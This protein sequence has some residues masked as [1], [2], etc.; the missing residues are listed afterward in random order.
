LKIFTAK[1]REAGIE[2]L[3]IKETAEA[4]NISKTSIY[5]PLKTK[6]IQTFKQNGKTYIDESGLNIIKAY[7]ATE[8]HDT[9]TDILSNTPEGDFQDEFQLSNDV[10][11]ARIITLLENERE[12]KNKIIQAL[13]Q[14]NQLLSNALAND[15]TATAT[16]AKPWY[17][18]IFQK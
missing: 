9:I 15:E 6:G 10:K 5:N 7:Y 17:K 1:F 3:T 14:S 2:M 18:R 12:E 11:N 8:Q 13:I 16:V 4:V